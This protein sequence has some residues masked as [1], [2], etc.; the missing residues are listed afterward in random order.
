MGQFIKSFSDGS[1][2]EYDRGSFDD[3][4]VYLTKSNGSRKPPRDVDYFSQLKQL[5]NKYGVDQIYNDY[6][7]IYGLTGKQVEEHPL[8][9][10]DC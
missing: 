3:W 2:L 7:R 4:C 10:N 8:Y 9:G 5:A 6:V 1:F